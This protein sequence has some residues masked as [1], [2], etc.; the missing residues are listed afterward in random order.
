MW[1]RT[2]KTLDKDCSPHRWPHFGLM[3]IRIH[4]CYVYRLSTELT[5]NQASGPRPLHPHLPT[6]NPHFPVANNKST[7][8]EE[9]LRRLS[10]VWRE[11]ITFDLRADDG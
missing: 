1:P 9:E 3:Q 6:P 8:E 2:K 4:C 11:L 5:E 10:S 7:T